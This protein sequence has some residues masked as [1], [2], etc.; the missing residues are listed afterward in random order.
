MIFS[1][2][3]RINGSLAPK[4]GSG[5]RQQQQQNGASSA[6][7]SEHTGEKVIRQTQHS[8]E[9]VKCDEDILGQGEVNMETDGEYYTEEVNSFTEEVNY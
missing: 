1:M 5:Q 6:S 7:S 4:P 8:R 2:I 9:D 3:C